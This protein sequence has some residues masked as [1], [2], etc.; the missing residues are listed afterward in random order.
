MSGGSGTDAPGSFQNHA[1]LW[2]NG[3]MTDLGTL[4]G[5]GAIG[6]CGSVVRWAALPP[7]PRLFGCISG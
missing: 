3:T 4:G 1:F 2:Q 5:V 6:Y 7:R